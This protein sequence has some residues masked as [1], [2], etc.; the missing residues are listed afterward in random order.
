MFSEDFYFSG[1]GES[2]LFC[3]SLLYG[4]IREPLRT[5]IFLFM[6]MR[7]FLLDFH[8][9]FLFPLSISIHFKSL[10]FR[11]L[12]TVNNE[13]SMMDGMTCV[14]D[15]AAATYILVLMIHAYWAFRYLRGK[16]TDTKTMC[17]Y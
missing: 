4:K 3:C 16:Y 12:I 1:P 17:S 5:R 2:S 13:K 8:I 15:V 9:C 7:K 14:P 11:I 10:L 6:S